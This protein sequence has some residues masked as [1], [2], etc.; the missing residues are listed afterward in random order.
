MAERKTSLVAPEAFTTFGDLLKYL[1]RRAGLTQRELSLE[2]GYSEP[3]IS[4]LE[5]N[6]RL[7][8]VTTVA[9]RFLPAL[10]LAYDSPLARRLIELAEASH[11][12]S[13][14]MMEA[15][16][17][18]LQFFDV[19][20]ADLFYGR[21]L[22]TARLVRHLRK[23]QF[24]AIVVGASG[25]GKSSIVRAGLIPAL[26]RG[27]RLADGSLPP[28]GSA[29]WKHYV[30][31]PGANPLE[32]LI[33]ALEAQAPGE[34]T[35][36]ESINAFVG[37][38]TSLDQRAGEIL[39]SSGRSQTSN[40]D[41][42][43]L[44]VDQFEEVFTSCEDEALRRAF[45][46]NLMFSASS[47]SAGLV[48]VVITLR[49]D[50][51]AHCAHY[52]NLR[53]G[54]ARYQEYIGPMSREEIRRAIEQPALQAG[55]N[56]EPGLVDFILKDTGDEPGALPLL[57]HALLETWK[58]RQH[59]TL[60][61]RGYNQSGGI[62]GAIALTAENVYLQ[63]DAE[64]Q[65]AARKIFLALTELGQTSEDGLLTPDTRR[66][67]MLSEL[68]PHQTESK[69]LS[70]LL[71]TLSDARLIIV[72]EDSVEVAHEA[73]I[74]EWPRL[75]EWLLD[76]REHLLLHRQLNRAAGRWDT[77]GRK[78][79]DLY[80]G[81]RLAQALE[82]AA[83]Y[84]DELSALERSFLEAS[85]AWSEQESEEREARRRNELLAAQRLVESETR[86]AEE[87]QLASQQLRRRAWILGVLLILAGVLAAAALGLSRQRDDAAKTAT[88]RELASAS[89]RNLEV[90]PERS[91]LLALEALSVVHTREAEEALHRAVFASRVAMTLRGHEGLVGVAVYSPDGNRIATA[92]EDGKVN[93]WE[94]ESGKNVLTLSGH[95]EP[96]YEVIFSA[97]GRMIATAG[98]DGT[99]RIWD[100]M[101]AESKMVLAGQQPAI[102]G[103][104]F[105]RDEKQLAT[106]GVD[107]SAV[108]W[109]V[110]SGARLRQF[111]GHGDVVL[112]AAFTPDG[113]QLL[114]TGWDAKLIFWDVASGE[115]LQSWEG[116]FDNLVFSD[117]GKRLM[118]NFSGGARILDV[119]SGEELVKT[120]GHT[121]LVLTAAIN[122]D[123]SRIA[124]A[125]M[126]R[127]VIIS[128]AETGRLLL[129]L[130]GHTGGILDVHFSPEGKHLVT[131]SED[132]TVRVWNVGPASEALT[133]ET[134]ES[135]G[136]I[137]LSPDGTVIAAGDLEA[138]K[139]WEVATG[140]ERFSLE[141]P[142]FATG[143]AL[144]PHGSR[145]AGATETGQVVI[146]NLAS[147]KK[148]LE[149]K[150]SDTLI[151][152]LAFSPDGNKLATASR[153]GAE[154][155]DA[156]N[157][158][159]I[160]DF[161]G[162]E[163]LSVCFSPDSRRLLA[164]GTDNQAVIWDIERGE[165]L[166]SAAHEGIIW[167][168][169]FNPDGSRFA[170]ASADGTARIWDA[171]TGEER[172]RL[173]GHT[174]TVVSVFFSPDG[175]QL[176]TTGRDGV[177]KLWDAT[178][179]EL[180]LNLYGD[181]E[182]L[183]GVAISP[184]GSR[185]ATAGNRALHLYLLRL[186]DLMVLARSRLTRALT[187]EECQEYLHVDVCPVNP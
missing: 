67:A 44:I 97:S 8:D 181:G 54:L 131:A 98:E 169:A 26:R 180:L 104:A 77:D 148:D 24:L 33:R 42:M 143:V 57:S 106:G 147:G 125:G 60:T 76:D 174:S 25:S 53:D 49:A 90:D 154:V 70:G 28:P 32:S 65:A 4:Y 161:L 140:D 96:V 165:R 184:D 75:R 142:A 10:D 71:K 138:V 69:T 59:L 155:W 158:E 112:S 185:L 103:L 48:S 134:T 150:A 171:S 187:V 179:G 144:D 51:Y 176:A 124:T 93:I 15:P 145:L 109:D 86:R 94:A 101:T 136:R 129:T 62:R 167:G 80:R 130:S 95:A 21:E 66:R 88:S 117:D 20:D 79:D 120:G 156:S 30:I 116:E 3:Q 87:H 127:K 74:R 50:F 64:Q 175:K 183:N 41:H 6:H 110:E 7:P 63:L 31:T 14:S 111:H 128:D 132:G 186:P 160:R 122:P 166:V 19:Q 162:A 115:R 2:V 38:E 37:D 22:L 159:L 168:C 172:L 163:A 100:A 81:S 105:S 91:I 11:I 139:V 73:L 29:H 137:A 78:P 43:V 146:W 182:G 16:Y 39:R 55:L 83:K 85:K 133:I 13:Q 35:L 61:F 151:M 47:Q 177:T 141:M 149:F 119:A 121:N 152:F 46:D 9:A 107:G 82:W 45:I 1:R 164:T 153:D 12:E 102:V 89:I 23:H 56:F 113:E 40:R 170:T 72:T 5:K 34:H 157:G 135:H 36:S 17:K 99:T 126:D 27:Q 58:R 114:T 68:L 52:P 92:G 18:G 123:W 178:S 118:A 173:I 108:V 84:P